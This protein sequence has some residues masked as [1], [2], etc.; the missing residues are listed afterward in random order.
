MSDRS[1]RPAAVVYEIAKVGYASDR[2]NPMHVAIA[3][4]EGEMVAIFRCTNVPSHTRMGLE[5][6]L[7][8][9]KKNAGV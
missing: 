8:D 5:Q 7:R 9:L 2:P 1:M 4:L 6:R 3:H